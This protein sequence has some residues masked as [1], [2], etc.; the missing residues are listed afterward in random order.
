MGI[1]MTCLGVL[2]TSCPIMICLYGIVHLRQIGGNEL[3]GRNVVV[4]RVL[5]SGS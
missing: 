1:E 4:V 2:I 5:L 3:G